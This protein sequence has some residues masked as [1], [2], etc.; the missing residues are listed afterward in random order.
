MVKITA[1]AL[2]LL[3]LALNAFQC[4]KPANNTDTVYRGKLVSKGICLNYTI[5]LVGGT[6]DTSKVEA[7]WTHPNTGITY[8]NAFAL[9][10][11]CDFPAD[12][13]EGDEFNFV[14]NSKPA[15][16]CAVCMA[17][18]PK[19]AKALPIKVVPKP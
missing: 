18:A 12:I 3:S 19:P 9:G 17:Y 11:I 4:N 8:Q 2:G 1:L 7:Q 14:L 13:K 15:E 10:S 16:G 6:L 5:T